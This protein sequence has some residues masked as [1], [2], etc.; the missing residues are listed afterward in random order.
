MNFIKFTARYLL[1]LPRPAAAGL[2]MTEMM[3]F[4][5]FTLAAVAE[6]YK[7]FRLLCVDLLHLACIHRLVAVKWRLLRHFLASIGA[8]G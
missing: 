6:F 7:K 3:N 1:G 2:A 8:G 5:K 4:I